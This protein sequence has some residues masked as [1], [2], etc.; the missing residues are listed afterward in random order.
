MRMTRRFW[1]EW[2][3][4]HSDTLRRLQTVGFLLAEAWFGCRLA[5]AV[6][7][8]AARLPRATRLWFAE[9]ADVARAAALSRQQR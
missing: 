3:A 9:F 4:L 6:R 5:P 8:E 7:E 1:A 2:R